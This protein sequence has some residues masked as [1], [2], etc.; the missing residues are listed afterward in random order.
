LS[1]VTP[2]HRRPNLLERLLRSLSEQTVPADEFEVIVIDDASGDETKQVLRRWS[3]T[4]P[5][6]RSSAFDSRE[7]I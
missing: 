7:A 3:D 4:R 1:I 2:T 6:F 5:S